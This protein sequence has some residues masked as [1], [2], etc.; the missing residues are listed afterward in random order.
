MDDAPARAHAHVGGG[1]AERGGRRV[2]LARRRCDRART[3]GPVGRPPGRPRPGAA[4]TRERPRGPGRAGGLPV[5]APAVGVVIASHGRALRLRWLLNA[6]EEQRAAG[7][8]EVVVV[9]D[10]EAAERARLLDD[11]SLVRTRAARLLAIARG[12]GSPARQRNLGWRT[13]T[14]SLIAFTDDD[15]RPDPEWLEALVA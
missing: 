5:S 1:G 13:A 3:P 2:A 9:H 7:P 15:C 11:H 12:S 8:F 14:A 6:L 4:D 10:Y